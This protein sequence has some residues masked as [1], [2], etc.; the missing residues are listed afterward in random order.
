MSG[1]IYLIQEDDSLLEMAQRPYDRE[2]I[3]QTLLAKYPDLLAGE[4]VNPEKPRRWLLVSREIGI[5]NEESGPE[6]WSLDHLFLDQD[7]IPTLVEVK[8][9]SDNRIRREVV[10]QML[11]Y[12]ANAVVYWPIETIRAKFEANC[13]AEAEDPDELVLK[14]IES[15]QVDVQDVDGFWGAVKIN[16]QAGK[17]RLI[18]VADVIPPELRRI[19]EF[20]NEQ[21]DPA[22]VL[23]VEVRQYIGQGL[24]TLVP[25][26]VGQ[27]AEA[28][29][30]KSTV[31][32]P[33]RQWDEAIFFEELAAKKGESEI[34]IAGRI[35]EWAKAKTDYVWWGK[36]TVWGS[37]V[38]TIKH[39]GRDHQLFVVWTLGT[40][41]T[42][43]QHYKS[44]PPFDETGKRQQLLRKLNGITGV[45][46]PD[47]SI[48]RRPTIPIAVF[49]EPNKLQQFLVIYEWMIAE[50]RST[51]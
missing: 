29:Q 39:N 26:V 33:K 42:Y 23:A 14:L 17:V 19:V 15:E 34:L 27:T 5:P 11:D 31:S 16:L 50:I 1:K 20:L 47:D 46:L 38:P 51:K 25:R 40:I 10:G 2:D 9:S 36:G 41:E 24:K 6:H 4:Q 7:G 18:F 3:L 45:D 49:T 30:R 8:R 22:E 48:S 43:F 13:E 37:F 44:K 35:L 12:A 21:M 32:R 28:Q